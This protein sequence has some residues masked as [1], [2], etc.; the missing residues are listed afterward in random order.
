MPAPTISTSK[1]SATR[2][3][4]SP[5]IVVGCR[6]CIPV[7]LRFVLTGCERN[8]A[9]LST[10]CGAVPSRERLFDL[11]PRDPYDQL[12]ALDLLGH[13]GL[14]CH[15][16]LRGLWPQRAGWTRMEE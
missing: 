13:E 5:L 7:C 8:A 6:S 10:F 1:C 11:H 14:G 4:A 9:C 3:R 12:P 16:Q 2:A 15:C